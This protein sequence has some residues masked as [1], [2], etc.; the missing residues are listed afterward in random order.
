MT[1]NTPCLSVTSKI[2]LSIPEQCAARMYFIVLHWMLGVTVVPCRAFKT[3]QTLDQLSQFAAQ[4]LLS[5][6][7]PSASKLDAQKDGL[8]GE[9]VLLFQF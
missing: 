6:G 4:R 2:T 9:K 1:H 3:A 8:C 7:W 5:L